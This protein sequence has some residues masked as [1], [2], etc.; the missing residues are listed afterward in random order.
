MFSRNP[1]D[2]DIPVTKPSD[3]SAGASDSGVSSQSGVD[4]TSG[5]ATVPGVTSAENEETIQSIP[6][7]SLMVE[8][9]PG[10]IDTGSVH[11]SSLSI[12]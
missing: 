9:G 5:G 6:I 7:V 12:N 11:S 4:S 3:Q 2:D 10:T 8:G 1:D